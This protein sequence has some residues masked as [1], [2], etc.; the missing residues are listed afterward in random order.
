MSQ[1]DL[2]RQYAKEAIVGSSESK[3]E[4]EKQILS[5]VADMWMKAALVSEKIFSSP[6]ISPAPGVGE[7]TPPTHS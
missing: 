5:G 1:S 3:D 6:L 7:A 2:F 4:S